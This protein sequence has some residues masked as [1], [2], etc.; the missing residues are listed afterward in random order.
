MQ[1]RTTVTNVEDPVKR[2]KYA[3]VC[4]RFIV[5]YQRAQSRALDATDARFEIPLANG[6]N[7]VKAFRATYAMRA[8]DGRDARSIPRGKAVYLK[9]SRS[10]PLPFIHRGKFQDAHSGDFRPNR[11]HASPIAES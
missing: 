1:N 7:G 11:Q 8:H 4:K 6:S 3:L 9:T 2:W 10:T 5:D